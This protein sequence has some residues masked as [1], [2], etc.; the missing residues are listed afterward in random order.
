VLHEVGRP[1][2]RR[3]LAALVFEKAL[4]RRV[5]QLEAGAAVAHFRRV[6]RHLARAAAHQDRQHGRLGFLIHVGAHPVGSSAGLREGGVFRRLVVPVPGADDARH[7]RH[8]LRGG[9]ELRGIAR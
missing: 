4:R 5:V 8:A 7:Q 6:H 9:I 1:E 3:L 2:L